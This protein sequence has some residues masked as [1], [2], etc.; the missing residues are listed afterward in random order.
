M[1]HT[2]KFEAHTD[3][4]SYKNSQDYLKP[5]VSYC[6]DKNE[7][8]FEKYKTG[9][10]TRIVAT[11]N[12]INTLKPTDIVGYDLRLSRYMLSNIAGIEIDGVT[13]SNV[14]GYYTFT[15]SGDHTIKYTLVDNTIIEA[16][17]FMR[18][19]RMTSISLPDT[20]T[21]IKSQAFNSCTGLTSFVIPSSVTTI[22][23]NAFYNCNHLNLITCLPLVP[24]SFSGGAPFNQTNNCPIHVPEESLSAYLSSSDWSVYSKR[25]Y[26]IPVSK[27]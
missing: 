27:S 10:D 2:K 25:I 4:V 16:A 20:V 6:G 26:S 14:T 18:C 22:F 12:I 21:E 13:Q 9:I 17:A 19:G 11:F 8:H 23:G 7:L 24:P 3:Y 15:S 5:N 1:K